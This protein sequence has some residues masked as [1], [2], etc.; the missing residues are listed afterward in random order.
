MSFYRKNPFLQ[1]IHSENEIIYIKYEY[2]F[3]VNDDEYLSLLKKADGAFADSTKIQSRLKIPDLDVIYEGKNTIIRNFQDIVDILRR[4]AKNI[5]KHFTRELGT[6][7]VQEGRRLIIIKKVDHSTLEK[8]LKDYIGMYVTC[9]ECGSPD[10]EIERV[11]RVYLLVCKACGAQHSIRVT[12]DVKKTE[13]GISEG[14]EYKVTVSEI[15][16]AGEGKALYNGYTIL[17]PG[18]KRGETV[19]V[20]IKKIRGKIA[21]GERVQR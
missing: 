9:Y 5:I 18:S 2:T 13:T 12:G 6:K 21:I 16:R 1:R 10:T 3:M 8:K 14:K 20:R 11:G 7:I 4:D 19:V 17:I 15:G